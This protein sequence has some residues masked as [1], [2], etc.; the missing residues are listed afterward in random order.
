LKKVHGAYAVHLFTR[1][2]ICNYAFGAR[3][4]VVIQGLEVKNVC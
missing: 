2:V 1:C 3:M 4:P